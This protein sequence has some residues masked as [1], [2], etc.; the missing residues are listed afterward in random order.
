MA[1]NLL[2]DKKPHEVSLTKD[3][4]QHIKEYKKTDSASFFVLLFTNKETSVIFIGTCR[5][6]AARKTIAMSLISSLS[7]PMVP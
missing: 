6:Y 3:Y 4:E 2:C 7:S 5:L 1:V